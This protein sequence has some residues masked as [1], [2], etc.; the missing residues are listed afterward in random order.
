MTA[1]QISL[2]LAAMG[3]ID[4]RQSLGGDTRRRRTNALRVSG[5]DETDGTSSCSDRRHAPRLFSRESRL[6][7]A[8]TIYLHAAS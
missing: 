1:Q 7:S 2:Q 6:S 5:E 8:K 4:I 3:P